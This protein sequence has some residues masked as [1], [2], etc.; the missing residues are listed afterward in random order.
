MNLA[1]IIDAAIGGFL[2]PLFGLTSVFALN[3]LAFVLVLFAISAWK[4]KS[5]V[6]NPALESFFDS[7]AGAVRYMLY[8]PGVQIVVDRRITRDEHAQ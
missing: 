7:L 2:A 4:P 8:A 3:A 5:E 1:G 6:L